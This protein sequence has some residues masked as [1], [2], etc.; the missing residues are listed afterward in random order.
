MKSI[1]SYYI[2]VAAI[3]MF[4]WTLGGITKDRVAE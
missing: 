4:Y 3:D 1:P 2:L